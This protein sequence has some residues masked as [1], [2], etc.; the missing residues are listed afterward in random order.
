MNSKFLNW[1]KGQIRNTAWNNYVFRKSDFVPYVL[2]VY[3]NET[4]ANEIIP[5]PRELI[6]VSLW[7]FVLHYSWL[8]YVRIKENNFRSNVLND[9]NIENNCFYRSY[10]DCYILLL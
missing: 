5:N 3:E 2:N 7:Y 1:K 10:I 9:V 6:Y 4:V 8:F